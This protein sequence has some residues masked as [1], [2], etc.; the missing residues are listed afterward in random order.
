MGLDLDRD[1]VTAPLERRPSPPASP[2]TVMF[3]ARRLVRGSRGV[4]RRQPGLSVQN[5]M[6]RGEMIQ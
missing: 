3:S 2:T 6:P 4:T 1:R 5:Q